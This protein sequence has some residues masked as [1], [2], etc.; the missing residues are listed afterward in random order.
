MGNTQ[1][2]PMS[3]NDAVNLNHFRL[4]RV[5]GKGAFGKVR[6][7]E[8]KDTGLTF[9]LKYIRKEEVVRSESVRNIIRERRML[10]HLNH[11][12][13]CNLRYSFQDMEYIYI[14]VDLMNGG[15]LRFHISRKCF[16]EDA[17]RFW[18]AE[19]GCAL[20]YIHSQGIIHRDL[21]PDNVLLDSDG[22]VHLADFNV[23]SDYRPG[24]PLTSKSGT[25]AY[26]APEVYEGTG[27]AFE[28]DWWSLGVTF[29]ECIYNKRPF[30]GRSQE[31]LSENIKKAQPKYY[32]TNPAVSVACLRALGSLIQ[33]DRTQRIG[34]IGFETYT[35][36]M[37]FAEI[38]FEALER[39]QIPPVFRPSSEKTNFDATYDLEELLLEEAPLEARARRQKPRAELREDATAKEI[40]DE[41]LH[42]LIETMFEPFDYTL[43]SYQ[44]NAA[45]AIAAVIN[46]EECFPIATTTQG[47]T[48]SP[49]NPIAHA[50]QFSQ[51]DPK[52][53][54]PI[55]ADGSHYRAQQSDN[56][57]ILSETPDPNDP[58]TGQGPPSPSSRM[59]PSPPPPPPFQPPPAPSFH[60]PLPPNNRHRGA[61]RQMS[62]SGGV[63][64]V[65]NEAGSWSELA[66]NSTPA[67]GMDNGDD[68]N[69]QANGMLSFFSRKKGRDRSPKPTE[70]GVLGKE[71]ARQIIS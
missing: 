35:S 26:L 69:K 39:K 13:L 56:M 43:T 2:K 10:E 1:G 62:K 18:M 17:V 65:L 36:H 52:N 12:F 15:D 57:T 54:S 49:A 38:D 23:A 33:K 19:L 67:D 46:P 44:G 22:H 64:M 70:P 14:V 30:E 3:C 29:Y 5:V 24:K 40:R 61:T 8:R 27:Y 11:P 66:H 42:R 55:Q 71:G 50:R 31:T 28:V 6:I 48:T 63:Q 25:L 53:T 51:P 7:V 47:N 20:R 37:F 34:A 32:V 68:K 45:E 60:R 4:L 16:T 9:A 59:S 58:A 41:E 21:K